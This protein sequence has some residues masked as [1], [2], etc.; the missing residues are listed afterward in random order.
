MAPWDF[1]A[2]RRF[3]VVAQ[4]S[5]EHSTKGQR[6][7]QDNSNLQ[8]G[9]KANLF[10]EHNTRDLRI[11]CRNVAASVLGTQP[12]Q[13]RKSDYCRMLIA[14]YASKNQKRTDTFCVEFRT[15]N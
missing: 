3:E 1:Q 5:Q 7:P 6:C 14:G 4:F 11:S 13:K 2:R 8:K 10:G 9:L 15:R 12:I